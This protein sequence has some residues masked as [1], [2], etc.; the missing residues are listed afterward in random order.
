M[1]AATIFLLLLF[2]TACASTSDLDP[3]TRD[4]GN[5]KRESAEAKKE[6]DALKEK[7]AKLVTE[8]SFQAVRESQAEL[9]TRL[10]DTGSGLQELRG[11]FEES[12]FYQDKILKESASEKDLVKAQI[13]GMEL[14]LRTLKEKM[15][16]L[17][18][19]SRLKD[20]ARGQPEAAVKVDT[21]KQG[22]PEAAVPGDAAKQGPDKNG[23][24]KEGSDEKTKAYETAYQAFKDK[25]YKEAREKFEAF[26]KDSPKHKLA[27]N[28]QFWIGEAYYAD[29]DYESAILAYETLLKKY[30]DSEKV[31][32]AMLKQGFAFIEI[33]DNKTGRTILE[34]LLQRHAESKE[35]ALAKK[36]LAEI[37]KKPARKK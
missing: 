1:R 16:L 7:T 22:Q 21:E 15:A 6:I 35:A 36:K 5:L 3:L 13:A 14:Q 11:R 28:A 2:V 20:P 9:T 19:A 18:E 10:T 23:D 30:P 34:K 32:G 25:K 24:K 27:G 26:M 37:E 29:K 33:G 17:E 8:E 12:K 31:S 4:I